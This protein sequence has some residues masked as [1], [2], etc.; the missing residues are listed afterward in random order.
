MSLVDVQGFSLTAGVS[1]CCLT[2]SC[3]L[4]E[5]HLKSHT[6]FIVSANRRILCIQSHPGSILQSTLH[7]FLYFMCLGQSHSF[8]IDRVFYPCLES[9]IFEIQTMK[10]RKSVDQKIELAEH[11]AKN[12][13]RSFFFLHLNLHSKFT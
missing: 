11:L 13:R 7:S 8:G 4:F 5:L 10:D 2:Y 6:L 9:L 1:S 12:A 3:P